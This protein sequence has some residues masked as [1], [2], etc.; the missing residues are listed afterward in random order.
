MC[1]PP[2]HELLRRSAFVDAHVGAVTHIADARRFLA[3][4]AAAARSHAVLAH[5]PGNDDGALCPRSAAGP[6]AAAAAAVATAVSAGNTAR[7]TTSGGAR[8]KLR[9]FASLRQNSRDSTTGVTT[10]TAAPTA[11]D[12]DDDT[13]PSTYPASGDAVEAMLRGATQQQQLVHDGGDHDDTGKHAAAPLSSSSDDDDGDDGDC[14][15]N[16]DGDADHDDSGA[17]LDEMAAWLDNG[18]YA[19]HYSLPSFMQQHQQ[20]QQQQQQQH[21]Q[22]APSGVLAVMA[23]FSRMF[24]AVDCTALRSHPAVAAAIAAAAAAT[25]AA[26]G[27]AAPAGAAAPRSIVRLVAATCNFKPR[28]YNVADPAEE[29]ALVSHI[30]DLLQLHVKSCVAEACVAPVVNNIAQSTTSGAARNAATGVV[31]ALW[32]VSVGN[33]LASRGCN[34]TNAGGGFTLFTVVEASGVRRVV[35]LGQHAAAKDG[36]PR[37]DVLLRDAAFEFAFPHK[38]RF[39]LIGV[40]NHDPVALVSENGQLRSRN[41]TDNRDTAPAFVTAAAAAAAPTATAAT[42]LTAAASSTSASS[43]PRKGKK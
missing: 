40:R 28:D 41:C 2:L 5:E 22:R 43:P 23:E 29:A 12:D 37:Y 3:E 24:P 38:G 10:T 18:D 20:H 34:S 4:E 36:N 26:P 42:A 8:G 30:L 25:V 19:H 11:A 6:A 27:A 32:H 17:M 35:A 33:G 21:Q 7:A 31:H 14:A 15:A 39:V 16:G 9:S 13:A 1:S